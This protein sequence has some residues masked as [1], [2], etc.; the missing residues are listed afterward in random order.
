[1]GVAMTLASRLPGFMNA[2]AGTAAILNEQETKRLI[3]RERER[4]DRGG[5]DFAIL[6]ISPVQS[7]V[8]RLERSEL[9]SHIRR[10]ARDLDVL[11]TIDGALVLVLPQTRYVG[12]LKLAQDICANDPLGTPLLWSIS[13]YPVTNGGSNK[14]RLHAG[15]KRGEPTSATGS[16]AEQDLNE[17]LGRVVAAAR[18][19]QPVAAQ[20]TTPTEHGC[21]HPGF[22]Q[23]AVPTWKRL[24]DLTIATAM[25]VAVLPLLLV[26]VIYLQ[27]HDRG[28]ILFRQLRLGYQGRPFMMLKLRTMKT[29]A[30]E[31][32][33]REH[34][35]KLM[36]DGLP[37]TK[38]DQAGDQRLIPGAELIRRFGIDELAQLVNVIRGEMSLIGPRP[39]L[40]YEAANFAPWQR[41]RFNARPGLTGLWQVSGKN[42]TTFRQMLAL[43]VR[44]IK[45]L[46]L[47]RDIQ[48]LLRTIPAV[49]HY[50]R[51]KAI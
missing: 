27:A 37:L 13:T 40:P 1:M 17:Q 29:D 50:A 30:A 12:A 41:A 34:L 11:G 48:I 33:H 8:N 31:Q 7:R 16:P 45:T 43:D 28:P 9:A 20:T 3:E 6:E 36:R 15:D 14:A 35:H 24:V 2:K 47:W 49:I 25:L 4:C 18:H 10:R 51:E 19:G 22:F 5:P 42:K 39:C 46:G 21:F 32:T 23:G 26:C 44:Y 38:L